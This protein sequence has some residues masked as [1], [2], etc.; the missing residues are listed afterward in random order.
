MNSKMKR[1]LPIVALI[2]IVSIA[3]SASLAIYFETVATANISLSVSS[4]AGAVNFNC[5]DIYDGEMKKCGTFELVNASTVPR[6]VSFEITNNDTNNL[7][8]VVVNYNM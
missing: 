1:M 6:T 4:P 2:L 8:C 3:T 7:D 5:P